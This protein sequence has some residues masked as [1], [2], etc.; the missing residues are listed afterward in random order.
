MRLKDTKWIVAA[1][2]LILL[3][4]IVKHY[5]INGLSQTDS[6]VVIPHI[7]NFIYVKNTGAAFS[8]FSGKTAVLGLISILFCIAVV[9]IWIYKKEKHFLLKLSLMLL[10]SGAFAN[11]VDRIFRGY[12]V[13]FIETS[14]IRFP[15][16][17]VADIA[18]T[19]GTA[20]LMVYLIFFDKDKPEKEQAEKSVDNG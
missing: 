19:L 7:L 6:I 13:D 18:I 11:A 14:F 17:N 9:C 1:I 3:D 20:F 2:F 8:M 10:F 16:F 15:V 5:V 4:Q 12:V